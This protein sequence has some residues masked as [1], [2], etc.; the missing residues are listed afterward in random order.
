MQ[1]TLFPFI[2]SAQRVALPIKRETEATKDTMKQRRDGE[3]ADS[4]PVGSQV[5]KTLASQLRHLRP[6]LCSGFFAHSKYGRRSHPW[7][8]FAL[9]KPPAIRTVVSSLHPARNSDDGELL[10]SPV[11]T[12]RNSILSTAWDPRDEYIIAAQRSGFQLFGASSWLE[13][14]NVPCETS[15]PVLELKSTTVQARLGGENRISFGLLVAQF[16]GS[17]LNTICGYSGAQQLDIFDLEDLDEATGEPLR[18]YN[19]RALQ[20]DSCCPLVNG[21]SATT[22]VVTVSDTVAVA[23]LSNGCTALV[24]VR[25]ASPVLCTEAP[26]PPAIL[27]AC[28]PGTRRVAQ[29]TAITAVEVADRSNCVQ[30][31]TGTKDGMLVLWDLRKR[32]EPVAISSVGGEIEALHVIDPSLSCRCGA[33]TLWLNTDSGNIA[34]FSIGVSSFEEVTRVS[35]SDSR[36]TQLSASLSP[37]KLSVMPLLDCLI[38][39][40][41]SS[42]SILFYDI[43]RPIS[44]AE[45]HSTAGVSKCSLTGAQKNKQTSFM[46]D[47]KAARVLLPERESDDDCAFL[48]SD[49]KKSTWSPSLL[50]SCPFSD[51]SHQLCSVSASNKHSTICVGGDDG[52]LHVLFDS[53]S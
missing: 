28:N 44:A 39:P 38:Y 45:S 15:K 25:A 21:I 19:L 12:F 9:G 10:V 32:N 35:T 24:D 41:I 34:C 8:A 51:W 46:G 29:G 4:Y 50:F 48:P 27:S 42:N 49:L 31:L 22:A 7:N 33:P 20:F 52:D 40:H 5:A 17:S 26:P 2:G 14:C 53:A 23:A 16:L 3:Y 43:G 30:L 13:D 37:P 6:H 1:T 36:R 18:T 11:D 47:F